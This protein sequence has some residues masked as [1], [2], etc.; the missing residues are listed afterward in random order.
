MV[1]DGTKCKEN[2]VTVIHNVNDDTR[3]FNLAC[4]DSFDDI[5]LFH[6]PPIG[7]ES[8]DL[9]SVDEEVDKN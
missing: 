2:A 7:K 8:L 4:I 5:L 6:F 1:I 3:S 9:T